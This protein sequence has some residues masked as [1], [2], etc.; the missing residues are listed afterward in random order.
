MYVVLSV[1]SKM[2][3]SS[4]ILLLNGGTAY[5]IRDLISFVLKLYTNR[6]AVIHSSEDDPIISVARGTFKY[7]ESFN[8][9]ST[10]IEQNMKSIA[11]KH[12]FISEM[13]IMKQNNST[14]NIYTIYEKEIKK[15]V[16]YTYEKLGSIRVIKRGDGKQELK[17]EHSNTLSYFY[18]SPIPTKSS[19][20]EYNNLVFVMAKDDVQ[21]T[22]SFKDAYH[23]FNLQVGFISKELKK[24]AKLVKGKWDFTCS[25]E[26]NNNEINQLCFDFTFD[27][28][29]SA[30]KKH[31]FKTSCNSYSL[32]FE[33]SVHQLDSTMTASKL[34]DSIFKARE[35]M[36]ELDKYASKIIHSVMQENELTPADIFFPSELTSVELEYFKT[37]AK[38]KTK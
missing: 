8:E 4:M 17:I 30:K 2:E 38:N 27:N 20:L 6:E 9:D 7:F 32:L 3:D 21:S 11:K 35:N 18:M 13:D 36:Q 37:A 19:D 29:Q 33:Q 5:G 25:N 28:E 34:F 26:S 15:K 23:L 14:W 16:V 10:K 1:N 24:G 31:K 12:R 22:E